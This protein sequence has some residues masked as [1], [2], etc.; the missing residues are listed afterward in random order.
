MVDILCALGDVRRKI[1][2]RKVRPFSLVWFL[3]VGAEF[4]GYTLFV[5]ALGA[6][7][8]LMSYIFKMF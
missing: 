1:R 7:V 6:S 5:G 8:Y 4:L 3:L 2:G